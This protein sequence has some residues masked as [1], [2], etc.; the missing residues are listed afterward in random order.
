[1]RRPVRSGFKALFY[2]KQLSGYLFITPALGIIVF[3]VAYPFLMA[4][5]LSLS[6]SSVAHRGDFIGL[7]NYIQLWHNETFRQTLQNSIVYTVC[8]VG[9]KTVLGLGLALVLNQRIAFSR[10]FRG[11]ILLPWVIP[12]TLSTLGWLWMFDPTFSVFNW[13]LVKLGLAAKGL[14]WLSDPYMAMASIIVVNTWRGLPF[15]A[16]TILAGLVSVPPDLYK[17]AK[18]DGAGPIRTFWLITLP[19]IKPLLLIVILFSTIMTISDFNIV[20][21]LT[22]G[23]PMNM[24][25]LLSTLSYQVGLSGGR[26]GQGAAVSLFMFPVLATVV[27]F[28]LKTI[29]AGATYD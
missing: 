3:L 4:I 20:Y 21:V 6:D 23:G 17:A 25:H 12:S 26:L 5:F 14:P 18:I 22:K 16:I 13:L 28:Q 1:M 29:R 10:L 9:A 15:F 7:E 24:T 27:Y 8:S 11:A 2:Q 19:L